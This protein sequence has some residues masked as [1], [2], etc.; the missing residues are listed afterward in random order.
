MMIRKHINSGLHQPANWEWC[1][2]TNRKHENL[3]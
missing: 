2:Y 1:I 3:M